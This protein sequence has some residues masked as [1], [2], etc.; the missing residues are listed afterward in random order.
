MKY[1]F[2]AS[3]TELSTLE[4]LG[5]L[6]KK[7]GHHRKEAARKRTFEIVLIPNIRELLPSKFL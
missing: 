2:S 4:Q 3:P 7:G 1:F 5:K 6:R